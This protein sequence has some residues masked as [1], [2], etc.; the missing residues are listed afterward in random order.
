MDAFASQLI[1]QM[2]GTTAVANLARTNRSTVHSWRQAGLSPSR[3]DHL[4]RIVQDECPSVDIDAIAAQHG[5]ELPPIA[6]P[7]QASPGNATDLT[8][9]VIA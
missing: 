6:A 9:P 2:G 7:V 5:V 1:D 3:L 8:A 4:R